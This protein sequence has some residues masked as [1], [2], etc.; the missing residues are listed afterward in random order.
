MELRQIR[1]FLAVAETGSVTR[2]AEMLHIVQ[3]AV[4]RQLK[5]LEDELGVP[6]FDRGRQGMLLT[7]AGQS[8]FAR[9]QRALSEID[10]A[11]VEIRPNPGVLMGNVGVGLLPSSCDLLSCTLASKVYVQHPGIKITFAVG[12]SNHLA[13]WLEE[14]EIDAALL[15]NATDSAQFSTSSLLHEPLCV[16]AL[17]SFGMRSSE[18]ISIETLAKHPLVLPSRK[19]SLR[20]LVESA[21]A[22]AQVDLNI[23]AE[24]DDLSTLKTLIK[25]GI[26]V[27]V[28]P[29]V[30]IRDEIQSGLL[31]ASHV[32]HPN[33]RRT[34]SIALPTTRKISPAARFVTNALNECIASEVSAG[35]WLDATLL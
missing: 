9:A 8:F 1:A 20:V 18:L 24:A 3:P 11:R 28:I 17:H 26:G 15:Y 6:L 33:F 21:C 25:Q 30:A 10:A 23:V 7:S 29:R 12:Y 19:H 14:G 4:S 22:P 16:C 27:T 13:K 31:T 34:I 2:A 35:S 5:L 32:D